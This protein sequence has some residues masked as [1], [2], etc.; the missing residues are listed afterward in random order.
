[1][2]LCRKKYLHNIANTLAT[3]T[4]KFRCTHNKIKVDS[5]IK[6]AKI[7]QK[8]VG[9][10]NIGDTYNENGIKLDMSKIHID[11]DRSLIGI[12]IDMNKNL[13]KNLFELNIDSDCGCDSPVILIQADLFMPDDTG[14]DSTFNFSFGDTNILIEKD[15]YNPFSIDILFAPTRNLCY[16]SKIN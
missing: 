1:M 9:R 14:E 12:V 4:L 7:Y 8:K 15:K 16:V 3:C 10:A 13:Q 5:D 2:G 6:D 11:D